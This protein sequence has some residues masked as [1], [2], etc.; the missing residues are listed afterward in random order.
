MANISPPVAIVPVIII[1]MFTMNVPKSPI[2]KPLTTG[3][4]RP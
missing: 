1:I 2:S 3:T 4:T